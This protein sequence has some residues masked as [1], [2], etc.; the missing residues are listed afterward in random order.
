[1]TD[2]RFYSLLGISSLVAI[3]GAA[4]C[5]LLLALDYAIPLT[6]GATIGLLLFSIAIYFVGK[7]TA[8]A[9]NKYLFGN[10]FMGITVLKLFLC[11]GAMV[12]YILLANPENKL[13]VIPFFLVYLV[14]TVLEVIVL[15]RLAATA[16]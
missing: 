10:A 16:K 1:M 4:A 8:I 2:S 12:G 11:G 7:R 5:H 14:F 3:A 6:A 13:F 9:E 15:V